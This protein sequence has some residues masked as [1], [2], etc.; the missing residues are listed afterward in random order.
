[1]RHEIEHPVVNDA[2]FQIWQEYAVRAWPTIA[3]VDP[4]GYYIGS[5]SG[6]IQADDLAP[7][8]EELIAGYDQRGLIDRRPLDFRPEALAE[9]QR[10]LSYPAKLLATGDGRLFIADTGHHRVLEV[11]LD[12]GGT[13]GELTRV[14]GSGAA[15]FA[16]GSAEAAA[17]HS[18]HGLALADETLYVADTD[19][20]AV[21]AVDLQSSTVRTVA[22]TGAKAHGRVTPG[23]PT[24]MPLRSPWGLYAEDDLVFIAM[25]GSHQIWALLDGQRLGPFAGNGYEALVDGPRGEASFNQPSDLAAGAGYLFVADAEASAIRAVA[26]D[27]DAP[28]VGEVATL[29]GTGLFDFG[30]V[31]GVGDEVR[32]QHPTGIAYTDGIIYIADSY[33]HKIKRLDP[34]N[35]EVVTLIGSGRSGLADGSFGEAEL[36]EPEGLSIAGAQLYVADTNNHLIRVAN[37][38]TNEVKTLNLRGMERFPAHRVEEQPS[39]R[40]E[41]LQVARGPVTL[42]LQVE[43][44]AGYKL[45]PEAPLTLR[46]RASDEISTFSSSETPSLRLNV[47]HDQELTLDLTMYP[48]QTQ[49]ERLCLIHDVRL[50][51]PLVVAS[52]GSPTVTASYRAAF[53][54]I[55]S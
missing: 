12:P 51:V 14:I 28:E 8:L 46:N 52:N 26:L 13:T 1:M 33:N 11:R 7:V 36:Y 47:E 35:R 22:G 27:P 31:D 54:Q 42:M 37:L 30:D 55:Q 29:V 38:A 34:Q 48:C 45:N 18:P 50:V 3:L 4:Q 24:T 16:D 40:L 19:N 49:D 32:L 21:R 20:H 25:A 53:Q 43:M 23:A 17:F 39:V 6:E 15:G 44:P 41:P 9:P 10:L 5:E 2:G